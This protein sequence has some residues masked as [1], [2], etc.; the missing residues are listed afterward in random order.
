MWFLTNENEITLFLKTTKSNHTK[1]LFT[2]KQNL[3]PHCWK[4]WSHSIQII[5]AS[6]MWQDNVYCSPTTLK[7]WSC[8]LMSPDLEKVQ[9][10]TQNSLSL[11]LFC[12]MITRFAD[13]L[14]QWLSKIILDIPLLTIGKNHWDVPLL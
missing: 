9:Y 12:I 14:I 6:A 7:T 4:Q 3:I 10:V 8:G 1:L 13:G 5:A 2:A 11:F